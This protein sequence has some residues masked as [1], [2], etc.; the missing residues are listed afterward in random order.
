MRLR[1]PLARGRRAAPAESDMTLVGH[2]SE[3]RTRLIRSVAA[4]VI[5]AIVVYI[6]KNQIFNVLEEPY[7]GPKEAAGEE[8]EFLIRSPLESFNVMLA[9]S[10]YGGLILSLPVIMYQ[11]AKFV[12]PGLYPQEKRM[13]VPFVAASVF[14]LALGIGAGYLLMP[15]TLA[16]LDSFGPET[17]VEQFSPKEYVSFFVKMLLAFGL[18]AE[19]PLVLIF[20]QIIGVLRPDTLKR[21]RR[22]AGVVVIILAAVITPT[23]DPFT[24]LVLA[25]PMYLFYEISIL[26][27]GRLLKGRQP[28]LGS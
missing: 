26:V 23:G 12:L 22:I 3:L 2:L 18:A 21:N 25:V 27:G 1:L 17:F 6:F 5:G 11:L 15:K 8:C 14:L 4:I 20:L 28:A 13:L 16:V 24:L 10:G 7:C 9:I 19:L